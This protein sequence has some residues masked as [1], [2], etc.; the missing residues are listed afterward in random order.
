MSSCRDTSEVRPAQYRSTRSVG[1]SGVMAEQYVITSPVPTT[2]PAARN[3]RAKS[4]S[5]P[6]NAVRSGTRGD[7]LQVLAH[8]REIVMIL[9]D[10]AERLVGC[11]RGQV[12][13][14]KKFQGPYPVDRLGDSRRFG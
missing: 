4:T 6:G 11:L 3:A 9:N 7:L 8:H 10:R 5:S 14:T 13:L 2:S 1:S 12:G